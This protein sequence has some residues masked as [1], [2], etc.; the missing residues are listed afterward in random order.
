MA[1]QMARVAIEA[2]ADDD[3]LQISFDQSSHAIAIADME[4]RIVRAN[5]A[6]ARQLGYAA[7]DLRGKLIA[8]LADGDDEATRVRELLLDGSE[9]ARTRRYRK[10]DG[11]T[12][13]ARERSSAR[14]GPDGEPR[15][16]FLQV[17]ALGE[18]DPLGELSARERE[19]LGLVVAGRTSRDISAALGIA[20]ASVDTYRSRIMLKLGVEDLASLV[21]FAIRHGI[22]SA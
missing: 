20:P 2:R 3:L 11:S 22:V 7:A 8:E 16:I 5:H 6:F 12:L 14:R 19:V 9:V 15:Y 13:W 10:R 17:D 21:R 4:G 1:V 18:K